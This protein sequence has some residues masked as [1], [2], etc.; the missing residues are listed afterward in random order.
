MSFSKC[1]ILNVSMHLYYIPLIKALIICIAMYTN[2]MIQVKHYVDVKKA[3]KSSADAR[4]ELL[5]FYDELFNAEVFEQV[6]IH[7]FKER[8]AA[9]VEAETIVEVAEKKKVSS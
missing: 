1:L 3:K 8:P 6:A 2:L 7:C 5:N 4:K 9:E